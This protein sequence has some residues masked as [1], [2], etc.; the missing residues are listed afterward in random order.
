[1]SV[2]G[3]NATFHKR[4]CKLSTVLVDSYELVRSER[5]LIVRA[6]YGRFGDLFSNEI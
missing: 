6:G 4:F 1:M 3:A 2:K 5:H